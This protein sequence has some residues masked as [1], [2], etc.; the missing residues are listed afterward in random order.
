MPRLSAS[1][2]FEAMRARLGVAESLYNLSEQ[3]KALYKDA[4]KGQD[5][6]G[7]EIEVLIEVAMNAFKALGISY[8]ELGAAALSV[9]PVEGMTSPF[10]E[11]MEV[12]A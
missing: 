4:L 7:Q 6:P 10:E 8:E 11:S 9:F 12:S 1:P 2:N 5:S 3:A